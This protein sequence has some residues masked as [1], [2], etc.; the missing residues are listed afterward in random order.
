MIKDSL[1]SILDN[2]KERTTNPFLGTLV[3]V[4]IIRNWALVY[5]LFTFNSNSNLHSRLTYIKQHFEHQ[6]FFLN[7]LI[8]VAITIVVL[9][10]TYILLIISRFITDFYD[11]IAIPFISEIT[12]KSSVVLKVEYVALQDVIKKLELRL[13]EE[14]LAKIT[15]QNERDQADKKLI[16]TV[17]TTIASIPA[18]DN[19]GFERIRKE[20][21]EMDEA[22][23]MN[24]TIEYIQNG[25][26]VK[27]NDTIVRK[28]L[29]EDLINRTK[30]TFGSGYG[31]Y[32]FTTEGKKFVRYWNSNL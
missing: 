29:R 16:E 27:I 2:I 26:G 21:I 10:F 20:L 1:N 4:W 19:S 31:G 9:I 12:D 22:D 18:E 24:L 14:R 15:A 3:V 17:P 7:M 13:E 30:E 6:S 8:V 11:K 5:A 25:N 32:T 23:N 28:L